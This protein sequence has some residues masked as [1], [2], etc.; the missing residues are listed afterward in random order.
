MNSSIP[1]ILHPGFGKCGSTS[2][3]N[4]IYRNGSLLKE[5]G[6]FIPDSKFQFDFESRRSPAQSTIPLWYF[7]DFLENRRPIAL[8]EERLDS[9]ITSIQD[10]Y[11]KALLISSEILAVIESPGT[12]KVHETYCLSISE[13]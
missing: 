2:I 7:Y 5:H 13:Y 12:V 9:I 6:I 4:F 8:L 10:N 3:Q 11:V 1:L